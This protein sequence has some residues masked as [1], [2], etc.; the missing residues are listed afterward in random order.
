MKRNAAMG[1]IALAAS[2]SAL[3]H[4]FWIATS[5]SAPAVNAPTVMMLRVGEYFV[6]D[7]VGVTASHAASLHGYS[8]GGDQDL[9]HL[10][11][12]GSMLPSLTLSFP[13]AGTQVL[14][15]ESHP[16]Q[17][18]LPAEKFHAYLHDE[19]LDAVIRQREA[20]GTAA[21]PGRERFRRS[22]K[23]LVR[24]GG[25]GGDASTRITGQRLEITPL[26]DPLAAGAGET[27][28]FA[29]RFEGQPRAGVLVKAWH[30]QGRQTTLIRTTTDAQGRFA[31]AL[32]FAGL[33]MLNAVH[34]APATDS[35][36]VDWDSYWGSLTFELS[37]QQ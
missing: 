27:L 13:R 10:V 4:E 23:T 24:V 37:R 19:G 25:K 17:I 35:P 15:Y 26:T 3:G 20:A 16:S 5:P 8:A 36:D 6:G 2:F 28:R 14:A 21:S 9:G 31:F 30:R 34:M 22:A 11:P 12:Q 1:L 32:P 18:V 29:L 7:L 33:W